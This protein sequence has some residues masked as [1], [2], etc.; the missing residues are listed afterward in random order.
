MYIPRREA[1]KWV[2]KLLDL[3][4]LFLKLFPTQPRVR[5]TFGPQF[6]EVILT[7]SFHKNVRNMSRYAYK[8]EPT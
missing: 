5:R 1:W 7:V 8:F 3:T 6:K 2:T 4:A